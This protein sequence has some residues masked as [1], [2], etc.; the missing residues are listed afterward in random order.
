M[1]PKRAPLLPG[2][3]ERERFAYQRLL[4]AGEQCSRSLIGLLNHPMTIGD[5][6]LVWRQVEELLIM[7]VRHDYRLLG[8]DDRLVLLPHFFFSDVQIFQ[9]GLQDQHRLLERSRPLH[10]W[11]EPIRPL[12]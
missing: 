11:C 6:V 10:H 12:L 2:H 8:D 9:R 1:R 4:G 7:L 3:K 5:Q